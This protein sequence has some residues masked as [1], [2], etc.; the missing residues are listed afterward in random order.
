LPI[1]YSISTADFDSELGQ[2]PDPKDNATTLTVTL[3]LEFIAVDSKTAEDLDG[4]IFQTRAWGDGEVRQYLTDFKSSVESW[5]N[6]KI[7]IL[8]PDQAKPVEAM[9][10]DDY[11]RFLSPLLKDKKPPY[12][13]CGLSIRFCD[14]KFHAK[15]YIVNLMPGQGSFHGRVYRK[16]EEPDTVVLGS[17]AVKIV[18]HRVSDRDEYRQLPAAHEIGHL[19]GL[20]HVNAMHPECKSDKNAEICYGGTPYEK[21]DIM[22]LGDAVTGEHARTWLKAIS[23]HTRHENGWNASHLSPPLQELLDPGIRKGAR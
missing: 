14:E 19:L 21:N 16:P 3:R 22:G 10:K 8:F 2:Q 20:S 9:N 23:L 4:T 12:L 18:T 7:F 13:K 6:D 5:W 15:V 1:T 17:D 11:Q